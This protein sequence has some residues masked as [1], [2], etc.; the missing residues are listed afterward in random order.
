MSFSIRALLAPF[1]QQGNGDADSFPEEDQHEDD[2]HFKKAEYYHFKQEKKKLVCDTNQ[3]K[4]QT[5]S[6][7][8]RT[9]FRDYFYQ[10]WLSII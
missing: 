10:F 9:E 8:V 2:K 6:A 7:K 1:L 4:K 5:F 3:S